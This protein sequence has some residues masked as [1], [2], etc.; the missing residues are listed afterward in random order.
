MVMNGAKKYLIMA[1]VFISI[2]LA[3]L[4]LLQVPSLFGFSYSPGSGYI[5]GLEDI[6]RAGNF[7]AKQQPGTVYDISYVEA[8]AEKY[9]DKYDGLEVVEIMEFSSNFYIEVAEIDTGMGAMELLV[10][11]NTGRIMP[12]FGPNMMWN[13]KYG[14]HSRI[15]LSRQGLEMRVSQE[16]AINIADRYLKKKGIDEW[17]EEAEKYYGYYTIHT[18]TDSGQIAGMLSVNGFTGDVWYHTWH[19]VFMDMVEY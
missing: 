16:E 12:E 17:A 4:I 1:V 18:V 8:K 5:C 10:D 7:W 2:G 6:A 9:L 15:P 19:G 3:G 13:L 11:K 14:M